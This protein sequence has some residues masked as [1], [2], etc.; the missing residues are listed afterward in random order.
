VQIA[1][2]VHCP[3]LNHECVFIRLCTVPLS[4]G[5]DGTRATASLF[6]PGNNK[7]AFYNVVHTTNYAVNKPT[8]GFT[9][10][11][12]TVFSLLIDEQLD[13]ELVIQLCAGQPSE[14]SRSSKTGVPGV[15]DELEVLGVAKC[16]LQGLLV[17]RRTKML[18]SWSE[19][20]ILYFQHNQI[21]LDRTGIG[22]YLLSEQFWRT[23]CEDVVNVYARNYMIY[24][25]VRSLVFDL[26]NVEK[27]DR[28]ISQPSSSMVLASEVSF[29]TPLSYQVPIQYLRQ[30]LTVL[31][32]QAKNWESLYS[33]VRVANCQ[34]NSVKMAAS[35]GYQYVELS[36]LGASNLVQVQRVETDKHSKFKSLINKDKRSSG[37]SSGKLCS[38]FVRLSFQHPAGHNVTIGRTRTEYRTDNP[39]FGA[40]LVESEYAIRADTLS[41]GFY[42]PCNPDVLL[43]LE[44][45]HERSS[46]LTQRISHIPMMRVCIPFQS[47]LNRR[48]ES[49]HPN[50]QVDL[51]MFSFESEPYVLGI[52][53]VGVSSNLLSTPDLFDLSKPSEVPENGILFQWPLRWMEP[54]VAQVHGDVQKLNRLLD[55]VQNAQEAFENGSAIGG[56]ALVSCLKRSIHKKDFSV[57]AIPTNL[58]VTYFVL[59]TLRPGEEKQDVARTW[60]AGSNPEGSAPTLPPRPGLSKIKRRP[61]RP[62][63]P[64]K[65]SLSGSNR[66]LAPQ[67]PPPP[68]RRGSSFSSVDSRPPLPARP[69]SLR[70]T[71]SSP[72]PPPPPPRSDDN[73][74][75]PLAEPSSL[76]EDTAPPPPPPPRSSL[77]RLDLSKTVGIFPL[78]T[79][80][81]PAAHCFNF[82]SNETL[83]QERVTLNETVG[84]RVPWSPAFPHV[85]PQMNDFEEIKSCITT[86]RK[87]AESYRRNYL[88]ESAVMSQAVAALVSCFVSELVVRLGDSC[89]PDAHISRWAHSSEDYHPSSQ[90]WV[91]QLYEVGFLVGWESLVSSQGKELGMLEDSIAAM[92]ILTDKC[93]F[94]LISY[95]D[96]DL[97]T[98]FPDVSARGSGR[99]IYTSLLVDPVS[100]DIQVYIALHPEDYNLYHL[101]DISTTEDGF[102][103]PISVFSVLFSQGINETQTLANLSNMLGETTGA[104]VQQKLNHQSL[105]TVMLYHNRHLRWISEVDPER[106]ASVSEATMES[107]QSLQLVVESQQKHSKDVDVLVFAEN[108]VRSLGGGRVTFCKSGKDRTAMSAT[109]EQSGLLSTMPLVHKVQLDEQMVSNLAREYG[110]RIV[111]AEKNVGRPK[112]SFNSAQRQL[113]PTRYRP[114][115]STIQDMFTSLT[116]R[117]S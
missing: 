97:R 7:N 19:E 57:G 20:Q 95:K 104:A 60:E 84:T 103:R 5:D 73:E 30:R 66:P 18:I 61:S 64:R 55:G 77:R 39:A 15:D 26:K 100:E 17:S 96:M 107:I 116:A 82:S 71:V 112:Y 41:F 35:C 11:F 52:L 87:H 101:G 69:A 31:A 67:R 24:P 22:L 65:G 9:R 37:V 12:E 102:R 43:V 40:I 54:H 42:V 117:D 13:Q 110:S 86:W 76:G 81:A 105:N 38:P 58:H 8:R 70:S 10:T 28:V 25:V 106:F 98:G 49:R 68:S 36:I 1:V 45:F 34:F 32:Q 74:P 114:P 108:T 33:Q 115:H 29:E 16:R 14:L 6:S 51:E 113:L 53:H 90:L 62:P 93:E 80:G 4:N 56:D 48:R 83:L 79:C 50:K 111:V 27:N 75:P 72:G 88:R 94:Y 21:S 92:H 44:L 46:G 3:A 89:I 63:P 59:E 91:Q 47:L 109:L 78:T 85:L 99:E 23:L 2:G